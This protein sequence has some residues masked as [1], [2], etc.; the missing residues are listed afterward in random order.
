MAFSDHFLKM[1]PEKN[2]RERS[3]SSKMSRNC[4]PHCVQSA[5]VGRF[6]ETHLLF[7]LAAG[8]PK[9]IGTAARRKVKWCCRAPTSWDWNGLLLINDYIL[10][11]RWFLIF[12]IGLQKRGEKQPKKKLLSSW[13]GGGSSEQERVREEVAEIRGSLKKRCSTSEKEAA[14]RR[15]GAVKN[16][17]WEGR[18]K[19]IQKLQE[20]GKS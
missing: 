18:N 9:R 14:Q 20:C 15:G 1:R 12:L 10:R 5:H 7:G 16:W 19:S 6:D 8:S 13:E 4:G 17:T 11:E 3:D 2:A